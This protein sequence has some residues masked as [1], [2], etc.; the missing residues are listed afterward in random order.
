MRHGALFSFTSC[1]MTR[2]QC[3]RWSPPVSFKKNLKKK[4]LGNSAQCSTTQAQNQLLIV[5]NPSS[6]DLANKRNRSI[7]DK[8]QWAWPSSCTCA[9]RLALCCGICILHPVLLL[10]E[11]LQQRVKVGSELRKQKN[12]AVVLALWSPGSFR[13]VFVLQLSNVFVS[14]F[15]SSSASVHLCPPDSISSA[16]FCA[17]LLSTQW[18]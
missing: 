12:K 14:S 2:S 8:K 16:V 7:S 3:H 5:S 18:R 1:T 10:A 13:H 6:P 11:T 17:S 15:F 9:I 4:N